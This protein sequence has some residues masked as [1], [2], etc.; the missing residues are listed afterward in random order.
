MLMK[1][2]IASGFV[3]EKNV[4]VL[5]PNNWDDYSYK[6][7]FEA[8]Y[9]EETGTEIDLGTIKIGKDGLDSGWVEECLEASFTKLSPDFF[10]FGSRQRVIKRY[11]KLKKN[12]T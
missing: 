3:R 9:I 4:M 1:Y 10:H 8:K 12:T 2:I 7:T 5:V 11:E 6:T